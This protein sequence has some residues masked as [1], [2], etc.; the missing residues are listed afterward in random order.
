MANTPT[1]YPH[2]KNRDGSY[3]SIC[4]SCFATI[5]RSNVEA[6]LAAF[7]RGHRCDSSFLAERGQFAEAESMR[8]AAPDQRR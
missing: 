4:P 8:L 5:A 2:R 3:D 6:E 7:D 1:L